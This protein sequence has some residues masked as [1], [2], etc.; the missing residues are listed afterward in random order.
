MIMSRKSVTA[1]AGACTSWRRNA[2]K[3]RFRRS[4][5]TV[6]DKAPPWVRVAAATAAF[7]RAEQ[8]LDLADQAVEFD[9]LGIVIVAAGLDR[10]FA[11]AAH[12]VRRQPDHRHAAR[13]IVGLDAS[14]RLPPVHDGQAHVH[15]DDVGLFAARERRPLACRPTAKTTS[16][17]RRMRRRDSMSRF[18]S[19]SSTNKTFVILPPALTVPVHL[20]R[21]HARRPTP[22]RRADGRGDIDLARRGLLHHFAR[23]PRQALALARRELL[24]GD[25]DDRDFAP[26][27]AGGEG[28]E[29]LE[30]VHFRHHQ[31]EQDHGRRRM[32]AEPGQRRRGRWR[33]R[34]P[35]RPIFSMV[36]RIMSRVVGVVL[37]DQ[38][39]PFAADQAM[40]QRRQ[41]RPVDRLGQDIDG[42]ERKA[43]AAVR[44]DRDHDHRNVAQIGVGLERA[45][46]LPA[47][48]LGHHDVE[49]D[50]IRA[51][52]ARQ[53]QSLVAA[54]RHEPA[55]SR[56]LSSW[57]SSSSRA[58]GSSST[59]QHRG[60]HCSHPPRCAERRP[61]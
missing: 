60:A 48:G 44:N 37:D 57:R 9:R 33:P 2:V 23:L 29:E 49:R 11:V 53:I 35:R 41:P 25:H 8:P 24:C 31:V 15:Q 54:A 16:K 61:A 45:Q 36:C 43:D 1:V 38:D 30:P 3:A 21:R 55:D 10:L 17:P 12:G 42:A 7:R 28:V 40:D 14:G 50:R 58:A 51:D 34:P 19:L 4:S 59:M 6:L 5:S 56:R 26:F 13:G 27:R 18:I 32:V 39:R 47:V 46:H 22:H 20:R 52:R